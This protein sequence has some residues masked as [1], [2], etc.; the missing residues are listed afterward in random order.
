[1]K[2][3]NQKKDTSP[4]IPQKPKI[5]SELP[6]YKRELTDK[7]KEFVK[8]AL[9]KD[10]KLMFVRGPAGTSKTYIS[11]YCALLL[12]N[13]KK[14]S[15]LLYV[16]S[17]TECSKSKIGFLPGDAKDK[18]NPYIQPLEDKLIELLPRC[19]IE[20]LKNES[21]INTIPIGYMRG[22][23]WNAK[24]IVVDEAQNI[25]DDELITIM[26]RIGEFSKVFIL[27]DPDQS[28]IGPFSGFS[29]I[30]DHFSDD[31]DKQNGIISFTFTED[32]IVRSELVKYIVK[33]LKSL[34]KK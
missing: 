14:V 9:N 25:T 6:I 22:L 8:H 2:K 17:A 24:C 28:D 27:G 4:I 16:R 1:M 13:D 26:T 7:Q 3:N 23:N 19:T 15:D 20:F 29:K 32:D 31:V 12:M 18:M 10:T 33:K 34:H 11:I 30:M 5:K 21:R